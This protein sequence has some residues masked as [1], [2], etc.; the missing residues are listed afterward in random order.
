MWNSM[1]EPAVTLKVHLC[2]S[3][4]VLPW[5][6]SCD[7][8][9]DAVLGL[10]V[11]AVGRTAGSGCTDRAGHRCL[12]DGHI[13]DRRRI[14]VDVVDQD[15]RVAVGPRCAVHVQ[16]LG[17][18]VVGRRNGTARGIVAILGPHGEAQRLNDHR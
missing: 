11:G 14:H 16:R 5:T 2:S 3:W 12:A 7:R 13:I 9:V 10:G 8:L 18:R 15:V 4:L 17:G 1:P 6:T